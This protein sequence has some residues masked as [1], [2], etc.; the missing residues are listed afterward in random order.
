MKTLFLSATV[1]LLLSGCYDLNHTQNDPPELVI[2]SVSLLANGQS[3]TLITA[4]TKNN[5]GATQPLIFTVSRGLL[6]L[7]PLGSSSTGASQVTLNPTTNDA[8]IFLQASTTP[9]DHVIVSASINGMTSSKTI[10]FKRSC[11]NNINLRLDKDT[12]SIGNKDV[13]QLSFTFLRNDGTAI[14]QNTRVDLTIAD[15]TVASLPLTIFTDSSGTA[16]AAIT[17]L[18]KGTTTF[19]TSVLGCKN[20]I[21]LRPSSVNINVKE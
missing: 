5:F 9:D 18:T 3:T 6:F 16:T 17:P 19:T 2:D 20:T 10:S 21:T 14:S 4:K 1:C 11:P 8:K 12:L 13:G 15:P 7:V